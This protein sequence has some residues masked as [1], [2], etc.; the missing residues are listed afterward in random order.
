MENTLLELN[1]RLYELL[2]LHTA[3]KDTYLR[4]LNEL[5]NQINKVKINIELL[6][7]NIDLNKFSLGRKILRIQFQE[8]C[9]DTLLPLNNNLIEA[10]KKD[11]LNDFNSLRYEYF[12]YKEYAQY[13]Q[14]EDHSYGYGP[15]H[16]S[17]VESI[18]LSSS[19]RGSNYKFTNEEKEACLYLLANIEH[20]RSIKQDKLN[21]EKK[22]D[23]C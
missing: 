3:K 2:D 19:Y 1:K 16:G 10:C 9:H 12:G 13:Y 17:I 15:S 7:N 5:D 20:L 4:E 14:R 18:G 11:I 6:N 22:K 8:S 23:I 21:E